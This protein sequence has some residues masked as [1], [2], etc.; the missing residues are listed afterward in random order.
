[1]TPADIV[2]LER[3]PLL[4]LSSPAARSVLDDARAQR[5]EVGYAEL[6]GFVLRSALPA[7]LDDAV[8]LEPAAHRSGGIATAYLAM[9]DMDASVGHPTRWLGAYGVGAVAYDQF[10]T[11]SPLRQLYEW[12]PLLAF[13]AAI[14]DVDV[15]HPYADP[16]GALNLAVMAAGDEL[17]WHFDMTDF[18]VSLAIRDADEGGDF[19]VVPLVRS[20][21]DER[22]DDVAAVL[23]G[24]HLGVTRVEMTPGTLLVFEGRHSLHRVSPIS[25]AT[26]RLVGLL[27]YDTKPGTCATEMLQQDR[28]GRVVRPDL[29][30]A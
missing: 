30:G 20:S 5:A 15:V 8:A 18:V 25:G 9:P 4:D 13:V 3:Y 17:Q 14:L 12:P 21:S 27:A 29:S 1:M 24:D 28:Y 2:D 19:E 7:L 16:L 6:A 23:E 11:S 26:S 22:Y 10:P